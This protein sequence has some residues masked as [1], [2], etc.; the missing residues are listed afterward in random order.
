M[1][2]RSVLRGA[3]GH[4]ALLVLNFLVLVGIIESSQILSFDL[5]FLNLLVLGYMLLHTTALLSVQLGVQILEMIRIRRPTLLIGYYFQME[6]SQTIPIKL[7]DPTKSKL[8]VLVLLLV[9]TGGPVLY[10]I[11]A[12][13]GFLFVYSFIVVIPLNPITI[14]YYFGL[15]LN[16]MPPILAF[17]VGIIII[18]VVIVEFR[19]L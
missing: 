9:V 7:L 12:I 14:L 4:L 2:E 15:F 1:S 8:A 17:I 3:L 10:P 18:S 16:W 6:D 19:H 5:P 13:Y 11:F